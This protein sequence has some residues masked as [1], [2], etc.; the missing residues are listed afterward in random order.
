M[1]IVIDIRCLINKHRT[2]VGE[3]TSELLDALFNIDYA[4]L[5]D[6]TELSY[7]SNQYFLFYNSWKDVSDVIP[8]WNKKNVHYVVTHFPNK[9]FNFLVWLKLIK[10]DRF[11]GGKWEVGSGKI[12][13]WFSPNID[14]INLSKSIKHILTIHDLSY[15]FFKDCYSWK[16]R[17]WHMILRPKKQ[18]ERAD[19]ILTPSENTA[20]D[21]VEHFGANQNKVKVL[22]PG[23]GSV[24]NNQQSTIK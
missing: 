13:Y 15:E 1:N 6:Y 7:Y 4:D 17:L 10:L 5:E 8:K 24:F 16:R 3:Y 21:V 14:F 20:R 2:G 18:G 12:D 19:I 22:R 11:V 23:L 9:I